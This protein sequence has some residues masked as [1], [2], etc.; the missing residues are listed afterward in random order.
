[1]RPAVP[2]VINYPEKRF[3]R[4]VDA[5]WLSKSYYHVYFWGSVFLFG[6]YAL[7]FWAVKKWNLFDKP[8]YRGNIKMETDI[9]DQYPDLDQNVVFTKGETFTERFQAHEQKRLDE[10]QQAKLRRARE[11]AQHEREAS[12]LQ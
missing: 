8:I 5:P 12:R 6:S 4:M 11:R 10:I 9:L 7:S 2:K 3:W 1:M